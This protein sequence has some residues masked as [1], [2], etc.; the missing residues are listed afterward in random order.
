MRKKT[1]KA[2][3]Y[4]RVVRKKINRINRKKVFS[5]FNKNLKEHPFILGVLFFIWCSSIIN[6]FFENKSLKDLLKIHGKLHS[7]LF[8]CWF[9]LVIWPNLLKDKQ[10]VKWYFRKRLVFITLILL[11]PLGLILLWI[12]AQFKRVTK[13]ILTVVFALLFVTSN[14]YQQKRAQ[15][16]ITMSAFDRV[17][18]TIASQ[19]NKTFLRHTELGV[20]KGFVF[21]QISKK[22]RTK[23]PVSEIYSRYSPSI[24]S[25]KTKDKYGKEIGMGSG[26]IISKNGIL[27]TNSHVIK[28]AYQLEVKIDSKVFQDVFVVKNNSGSDIAI[29]KIDAT[30]LVPLAIGDSDTLKSG[31][32]IVA[33]GNPMG[34]EQSV[35]S[36]IISAIRSSRNIKLIQMTT[37]VSPGSSGGPVLNEYGEVIGIAT[38]ASFFIAQNL[39]FAIPINYLKTLVNQ[40]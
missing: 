10:K 28:S 33:L 4:L 6:L 9:V 7:I 2:I 30:G 13:I 27:V 26:F 36:G 39:N 19:K 5:W 35:S 34:L 31:Q 15:K 29:L 12:G 18:N 40:Q 3:R 38:M 25:I 14:I 20:L 21:R 37:P 23:I 8:I 17:V 16:V 24:V 32:F 11:P 1:Y 22:E